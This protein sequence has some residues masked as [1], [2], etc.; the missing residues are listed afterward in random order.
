VPRA[1]SRKFV[2]A[3]A[4]QSAARACRRDDRK[5]CP[6]RPQIMRIGRIVLFDSKQLYVNNNC[7]GHFLIAARDLEMRLPC[8]GMRRAHRGGP[9]FG[10]SFHQMRNITLHVP[11]PT[12][13]V[14]Q[15]TRTARVA[16]ANAILVNTDRNPAVDLC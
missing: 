10:G 7:V 3:S 8:L 15:R 13:A 4:N 1:T 2:Y 6:E 14:R 5:H 16:T 9:L 11:T 12:D